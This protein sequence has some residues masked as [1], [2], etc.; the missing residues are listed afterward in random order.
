MDLCNFISCSG[1]WI[2][3]WMNEWLIQLI[4][5][6]LAMRIDR[7]VN[8]AIDVRLLAFCTFPTRFICSA[9][10]LFSYCCCYGSVWLVSDLIWCDVN[11]KPP[12]ATVTAF[13][14]A[15]AP[16]Y[17]R[18]CM[19]QSEAKQTIYDQNR[20][21]LLIQDRFDF[22]KKQQFNGLRD[23]LSVHWESSWK[24]FDHGN[25][26]DQHLNSVWSYSNECIHRC[27][28]A[29][30]G[31][32]ACLPAR[33][34]CNLTQFD[35]WSSDLAFGIAFISLVVELFVKKW[36]RSIE[37]AHSQTKLNQTKPKQTKWSW[38]GKIPYGKIMANSI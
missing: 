11:T 33:L 21:E 1:W 20:F 2:N 7:S 22:Q 23:G 6:A 14:T 32:H 36:S 25:H 9:V 15:R 31:T 19:H 28:H 24:P 38:C 29:L 26:H 30:F 13:T 12:F 35:K 16:W 3:E 10:C 8:W 34:Q 5:C 18:K 27:A 37:I 17:A 4:N